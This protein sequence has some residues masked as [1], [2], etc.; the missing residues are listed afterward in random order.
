M[1]ICAL[2]VVACRGL[3]LLASDSRVT[4][5]LHA[6]L[7]DHLANAQNHLS[8]TRDL[9]NLNNLARKVCCKKCFM[10]KNLGRL[11]RFYAQSLSV[12]G[13]FCVNLIGKLLL[14]L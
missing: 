11:Y 7:R 14:S 5:I 2:R 1:R 6:I 9:Y 10:L 8:N 3:T 12:F 13:S 4:R